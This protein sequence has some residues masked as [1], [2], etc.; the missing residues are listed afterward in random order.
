MKVLWHFLGCSTL[1]GCA[2]AP[3]VTWEHPS[4]NAQDFYLDSAQ[5]KSVALAV[6]IPLKPEAPTIV[7]NVSVEAEQHNHTDYRFGQ[8]RLDVGLLNAEPKYITRVPTTNDTDIAYRKAV[9]QAI[10]RQEAAYDAC[11]GSLGWRPVLSGK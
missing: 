1:I 4:K 7:N 9:S 5:C 2:V 3:Q 8:G 10:E 11:L 6:P